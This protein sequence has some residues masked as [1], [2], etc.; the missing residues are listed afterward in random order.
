MEKLLRKTGINQSLRLLLIVASLVF[1]SSAW[2]QTTTTIFSE[3]F[4]KCNGT[5]GNDRQWNNISTTPAI[6][7][8][9]T[10][11][12][13]NGYGASKCAR[14]GTSKKLG[15]ATTPQL[16]FTGDATLT[17]RAG[18]WSGDKT[19][20]KLS[21]SNGKLNGTLSTT[22]VT[23]KSGAFSKYTINITGV[24]DNPTIT[25][26]GAAAKSSRFFLDDV[27][28][29]PATT[30]GGGSETTLTDRE[31]SFGETTSF[32]AEVGDDTF[33]APTL[34]G[35]TEGA[36]DGVAYASNNE[37]VARVNASTG[38]VTIYGMGHAKIT[39]SAKANETYKAGSAFYDIYVYGKGTI[40]GL[41]AYITSTTATDIYFNLTTTAVVTGTNTS[42]AFMEDGSA[43]IYL[44]KN[45]HGL[46]AGNSFTG[47]VKAT[48]MLFKDSYELTEFIPAN[49]AGTADIPV[50][51]R[52]IQYLTD[53]ENAGYK[54][55]E[56]M[57][58]KLTGVT[59]TSDLTNKMCTIK[60]NG[61]ST[62][63][64]LNQTD[65]TV[66][67]GTTYNITGYPTIYNGTWEFKVIDEADLKATGESKTAAPTYYKKIT[68][69]D[70]LAAG[71]TYLIVCED[72]NCAIGSI[73]DKKGQPTPIT[74]TANNEKGINI[75]SD[76][77]QAA[78]YLL[79]KNSDGSFS[80]KNGTNYL[81]TNKDDLSN[82][83]TVTEDAAKWTVS[84]N[85]GNVELVCKA[86][87]TRQIIYRAGTYNSF[88]NYATTSAT[89]DEYKK[90]Q[91]YQK[92]T[93][94]AISTL[95]NGYATFVTDVPYAMPK[96]TCGYAVTVAPHVGVIT[97]TE[98]YTE[99]SQVPAQ[100][101]LLIGGASGTNYYP[102]VL[103]E[104]VAAT[105]TGENYMEGKR[106]EEGYTDTQ[107]GVAVYY[108]KLALNSASKP[109][110][111][112]GAADGAAFQLTKPTTAYLAVPKNITPVNGY[113]IDFD[114]EETGISTIAPT[115]GNTDGTIYNLN[116]IRMTQT[117]RNLPKGVYIV[118]G[119]KVIK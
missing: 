71:G 12:N 70:E 3:T 33:S 82:V 23:L 97:K 102:A 30:S 28:V 119:K 111:Y 7:A 34:T 4:D 35:V 29:T 60:Q 10:W 44:Y 91:L 88:K 38:E 86:S 75:I 112:Y 49:T 42:N 110:F 63:L 40:E 55:A 114:G 117:L 99:G 15:K 19:T 107:K 37:A 59:V 22:T 24:T 72:E 74:Y 98:A 18:A 50:T 45:G 20:L 85:N 90:V 31:L 105:Y 32:D 2:G 51:G 103:K 84:F 5:G 56:S 79:E 58:V 80:L 1:G 83:A 118:N 65:W 47:K 109:G 69:T 17:F 104:N 61:Y 89:T 78:E 96:G 39:A 64:Y 16:N 54:K 81:K 13:A 108:Y 66:T 77:A 67:N 27:V 73:S 100:T 113:L 76:I 92:V 6:S 26:E 68:S 57:R 106:T 36:T 43:G 48:G 9:N 11:T 101:A 46:T 93:D 62:T 14:Y 115:N 94:L 25:F 87:D 116:G 41:K 53:S 21:I 52:T 95:T 8:D